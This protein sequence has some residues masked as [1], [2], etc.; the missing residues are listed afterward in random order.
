MSIHLLWAIIAIAA[1]STKMSY[2]G[3]DRIAGFERP[4]KLVSIGHHALH[5]HCLGDGKPTIILEAGIGGNY[6]DWIKIQRRTAKF[7]K[8]CSYD[9][10][11]YGWSEAGPKPRTIS[12]IVAELEQLLTNVG[13]IEPVILVGHSF[14]GLVS[15][16][17]AATHHSRLAGLVLIDP[18]HPEQFK[19]FSEAG[20]SVSSVPSRAII[21]SGRSVL[22][23][24]IPES[25][26]ELAY[27]LNTSNKARSFMLNELRNLGR[28]LSSIK[29][30]SLS[31]LPSRL[32]LHGNREWD[33]IYPDGR[34]ED[35]WR[36]MH[37]DLAARIHAGPIAMISEAGHQIA[38]D[39]PKRVLSV[40][41]DVVEQ[42]RRDQRT[43]I[44]P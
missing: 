5:I 6:L 13:L 34:M 9:R 2:A 12:V 35:A 26:K 18:M 42:I 1:A 33:K 37:E 11:G 21:Y 7:T 22:T 20:V 14:G 39:A 32:I 15:L 41:R 30:G 31:G 19:R 8:V 27:E 10:T 38:L 4:G 17:F 44:T 23:Y 43:R 16:Q 3:S 28:S 29:L 36:Q 25:H 40:L 24:G